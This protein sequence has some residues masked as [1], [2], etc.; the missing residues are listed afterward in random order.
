MQPWIRPQQRRTRI[1]FFIQIVAASI[2]A[3]AIPIMLVVL[4]EPTRDHVILAIVMPIICVF[5][6]MLGIK[7][8]RKMEKEFR[9]E[10]NHD[11]KEPK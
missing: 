6:V 2:A 1:Y 7:S 9:P 11:G 8:F 10:A 3:V 5:G 4:Q